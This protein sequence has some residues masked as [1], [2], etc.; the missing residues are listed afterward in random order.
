MATAGLL[1]ALGRPWLYV[2]DPDIRRQEVRACDGSKRAAACFDSDLA[3]AVAMRSAGVTTA[4]EGRECPGVDRWCVVTLGGSP[5]VGNR[6][7][8][9]HHARCTPHHPNPWRAR[10]VGLEAGELAIPASP[11]PCRLNMAKAQRVWT[12]RRERTAPVNVAATIGELPKVWYR[13]GDSNPGLMAENHP[14]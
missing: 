12:L 14:S 7:R 11:Q 2:A 10:I 13:Y 6:G 1:P 9:S 8:H 4:R 5:S 3:A